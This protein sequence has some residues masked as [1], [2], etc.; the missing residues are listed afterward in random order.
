MKA[1]EILNEIKN[2]LG[3]EL[4]EE[5]VTLATMKLENGTEIESENFEKG[6]DVFI[7]NDEGDSIPLPVGDYMLEDGRTLVIKEEGKIESI[8]EKEEEI[9]ENS[10]EEE[11]LEEN[12]EEEKED[13]KEEMQYAT[14]EELAEIK[15]DIEDIKAMIKDK[16]EMSK[17]E[18]EKEEENQVEVEAE[19]VE[20]IAHNP[21]ALSSHQKNTPFYQSEQMSIIRNMIYKK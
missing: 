6:G 16:K 10:K 1:T 13:K 15:K 5:T 11:N 19:K 18:G 2:V 4:S 20:P 9:E 7:K 17:E 8:N 3:I 21:E 12:L 14:K